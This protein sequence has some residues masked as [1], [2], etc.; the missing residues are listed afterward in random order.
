MGGLNSGLPEACAYQQ[1]ATPPWEE[2]D[3]STFS[4]QKKEGQGP[5]GFLPV[6]PVLLQALPLYVFRHLPTPPQTSGRKGG[7]TWKFPRGQ[8]G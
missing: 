8:H 2:E 5:A 7:G 4:L 6:M 3:H 1:T